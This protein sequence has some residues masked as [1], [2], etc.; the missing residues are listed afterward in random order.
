[1]H[2]VYGALI[3]K[4]MLNEDIMNST[5]YKTY[6]VYASG[7][8]EPKKTRKFKNPPSPKQFTILVS[9]KEPTKKPAKDKKDV[10]STKK[11]N[12]NRLRRRHRLRLIEE[13]GDSR[14]EDDDEDDTEDESDNDGNDDDGD[15]DGN[16]DDGDN[17][18]N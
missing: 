10:P 17:D 8:K 16:D 18:D 14:E 3:P 13:K 12:L 7:A 4:E 1:E 5:A 2:Q 9:P 6:Y 11:P 15:N